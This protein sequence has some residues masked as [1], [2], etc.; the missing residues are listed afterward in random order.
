MCCL[1][2][3]AHVAILATEIRR[4]ARILEPA[5]TGSPEA[6]ILIQVL[7]FVLYSSPL[8]PSA[9]PLVLSKTNFCR[10]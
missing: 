9:F 6:L 3:V 10:P 5:S 1:R 7:Q 8:T 4:E 2:V